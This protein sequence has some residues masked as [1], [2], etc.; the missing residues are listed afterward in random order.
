MD[1]S[2]W[3]IT[4]T[5]TWDSDLSKVCLKGFKKQCNWFKEHGVWSHLHNTLALHWCLACTFHTGYTWQKLVEITFV[6]VKTILIIKHER[7]LNMQAFRLEKSNITI[8]RCFG[9]KNMLKQVNQK[10]NLCSCL[11][12]SCHI[13]YSW[14]IKLTEGFIIFPHNVVHSPLNIVIINRHSSPWLMILWKNTVLDS[15]NA[16]WR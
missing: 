9:V 12:F 7:Y 8:R 1:F 14:R 13:T 2:S 10:R 3:N 4:K 15:N 6:V 11:S 5:I 16:M